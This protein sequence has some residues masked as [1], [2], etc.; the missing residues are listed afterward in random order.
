MEWNGMEWNGMEWNGM[1]W[2]GMEW[3]GM[4]WNPPFSNGIFL[5][6]KWLITDLRSFLAPDLFRSIFKY[7]I[8]DYYIINRDL[9]ENG[10][11]EFFNDNR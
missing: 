2:N 10:R 4:E 11:I 6:E 1:E 7:N 5:A 9:R 3:N 8:A